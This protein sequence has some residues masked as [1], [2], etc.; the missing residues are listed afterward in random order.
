VRA[1]ALIGVKARIACQAPGGA[2]DG[3]RHAGA[4]H[5]MVNMTAI[6]CGWGGRPKDARREDPKC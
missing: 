1:D 6:I 3:I 2:L 5:K 4:A